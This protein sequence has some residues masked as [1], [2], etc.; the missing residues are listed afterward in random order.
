[1]GRSQTWNVGT[2]FL[3]EDSVIFSILPTNSS[4]FCVCRA[5]LP[6]SWV[7]FTPERCSQERGLPDTVIWFSIGQH[8]ALLYWLVDLNKLL[9]PAP[10]KASTQLTSKV[11][12]VSPGGDSP[13]SASPRNFDSSENKPYP[14]LE[15]QGSF[16]QIEWLGD[17]ETWGHTHTRTHTPARYTTAMI[18][19]QLFYSSSLE[20]RS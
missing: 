3:F 13:S 8:R 2:F 18:T 6:P 14:N 20:F 5:L 1:M 10:H 12:A 4:P 7:L 16:L 19:Q 11:A 15:C 17:M 9:L